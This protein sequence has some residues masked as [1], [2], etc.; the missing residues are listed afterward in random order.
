MRPELWHTRRLS[1]EGV[2]YKHYKFQLIST[3]RFRLLLYQAL[4]PTIIS[5]YDLCT[6]LSGL[7]TFAAIRSSIYSRKLRADICFVSMGDLISQSDRVS[8]LPPSS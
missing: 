4:L 7:D 5:T 6:H 2:K 3:A 8:C 1:I